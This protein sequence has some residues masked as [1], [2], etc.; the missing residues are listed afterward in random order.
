MAIAAVVLCLGCGVTRDSIK[1]NYI[2]L[3]NP[4]EVRG[5]ESVTVG[6]RVVDVRT[7]TE[8]VGRKTKEYNWSG[9]IV[10][11]NDLT[12]VVAEAVEKELTN[13]G[14][15]LGSG[16]V[17]VSAELSRFYNEFNG[18]PE[19][20]AAEVILT[21]QVKRVDGSVVFSKLVK[22]ESYVLYRTWKG[23]LF[24]TGAGYA[25]LS[26]EAALRKAIGEL[27]NDSAFINAL[28]TAAKP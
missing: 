1:I 4:H 8:N 23:T 20:A 2:P 18:V 3:D 13:R 27:I 17:V 28:F 25:K 7:N 16:S 12:A 10:V 9:S 22:G 6:V 14:F 11:E 21:A 19:E 5:A 26:L 24:R 15:K